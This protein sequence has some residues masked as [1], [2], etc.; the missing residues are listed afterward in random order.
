MDIKEME[1]LYEKENEILA[2]LC[3]LQKEE[4]LGAKCGLYFVIRKWATIWGVLDDTLLEDNEAVVLSWFE[5]Y[6][7]GKMRGDELLR[8]AEEMR[9]EYQRKWEE[10]LRETERRKR[11]ERVKEFF[12]KPIKYIERLFRRRRLPF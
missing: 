7:E 12:L 5:Q 1:R 2:R 3:D 4:I 10:F 6:I 11:M 9:A 8:R